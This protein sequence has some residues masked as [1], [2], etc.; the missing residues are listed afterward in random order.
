M[1]GCKACQPVR[2][3]R[4]QVLDL[5]HNF[6]EKRNFAKG[7]KNIRKD[8]TNISTWFLW[9][10]C[11]TKYSLPSSGC[12]TSSWSLPHADCCSPNHAWKHQSNNNYLLCTKFIF[13]ILTKFFTL[14]F[15][16]FLA[17]KTYL[18][19]DKVNLPQQLLLM[20][21]QFSHHVEANVSLWNQCISTF[22]HNCIPLPILL[23]L[24]T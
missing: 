11:C 6:P 3:G 17:C 21:L 8:T 19:V 24:F 4:I 13:D 12:N 14:Q 5:S 18:P 20:E 1:W 9:T 2:R 22:I 7:S 10:A 23:L 16:L 15:C